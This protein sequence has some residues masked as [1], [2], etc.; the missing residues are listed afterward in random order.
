MQA[1]LIV[2]LQNDFMPKG[3]LAVPG[4]ESIIPVI[5]ALIPKFSCVIAS[6]DWHPKNH[7][8]FASTHHKKIGEKLGEQVL[9]PSHCIQGTFGSNFYE[10]LD[11][12][13]VKKIFYKGT[14]KGFDS[15][16]AFFDDNKKMSTG[17]NEFLK[18]RCIN[19]IFITGIVLEY[20]VAAT[21]LDGVDLGYEVVIIKE[22]V[23]SLLS[24]EGQEKILKSLKNQ[25]IDNISFKTIPFVI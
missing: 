13:G 22:G 25:K 10:G 21:A 7:I 1:L 12:E 19:K 11:Q 16:S 14:M 2:D 4:V 24:T 20:C 15:Y 17:L 18:E 6:K 5:N 23:G 9:W 8:S 3:S